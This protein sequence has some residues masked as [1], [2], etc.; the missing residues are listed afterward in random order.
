MIDIEILYHV[1]VLPGAQ[2]YFLKLHITLFQNCK[3]SL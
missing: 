2:A 1:L 3:Q